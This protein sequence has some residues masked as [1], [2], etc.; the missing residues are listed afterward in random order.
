M[1]VKSHF[2][3][4]FAANFILLKNF[5]ESGWES[6][7]PTPFLTVYNSFEDCGSHRTTYTPTLIKT[8][9]EFLQTKEAG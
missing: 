8:T 1:F 4:R 5:G 9:G 6:N 7:P 2:F 3:C